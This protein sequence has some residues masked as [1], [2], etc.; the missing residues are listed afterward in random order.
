[1]GRAGVVVT[2]TVTQEAAA[3]ARRHPA[4]VTADRLHE[5]LAA[6]ADVITPAERVSIHAAAYALTQIPDRIRR[7]P[8]GGVQS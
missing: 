4:E 3:R 6:Y 7:L 1:M 8:K 5:H 2:A